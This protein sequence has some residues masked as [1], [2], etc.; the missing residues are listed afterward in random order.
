MRQERRKDNRD[1]GKN[2]KEKLSTRHPSRGKGTS[3]NTGASGGKRS[4]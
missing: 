3:G 4:L 2:E 1:Q